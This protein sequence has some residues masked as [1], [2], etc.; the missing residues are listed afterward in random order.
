MKPTF[1]VY[2]L[3]NYTKTVLYTGVTNNLLQRIFEHYANRGNAI[4]F[5]GKY[6][7]YYLLYYEDYNYIDKAIAREKEIKGW[8][9]EKK[10]QL[11]KSENPEMN[12]LNDTLFDEWPPKGWEPG[13]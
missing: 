7:V 2:I 1:Y 12:F 10:E 4:S 6:N 13:G 8:K 5:T 9:R 3:T 11:I